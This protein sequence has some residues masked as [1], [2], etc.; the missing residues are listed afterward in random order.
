MV[1]FYMTKTIDTGQSCGLPAKV[2][3]IIF[4]PRNKEKTQS[5]HLRTSFFTFN[6]FSN[7]I[8]YQQ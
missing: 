2:E 6:F 5:P 3:R 4:M 1:G 7:K 8:H